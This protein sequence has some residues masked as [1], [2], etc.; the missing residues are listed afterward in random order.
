MET[1]SHV[2]AIMNV[3][4]TALST[5]KKY[6]VKVGVSNVYLLNSVAACGRTD[7]QNSTSDS[8]RDIKPKISA[9]ATL[10]SEMDRLF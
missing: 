5:N 8:D 7:T 3:L 2:L 9:L 4:M 6:S 1:V 10:L